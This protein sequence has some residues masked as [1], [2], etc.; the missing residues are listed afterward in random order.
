MP[1]EGFR[2][3]V[4]VAPDAIVIVDD[5]GKIISINRLAEEMFGYTRAELIGNDVEM[6]IPV[7]HLSAH[8]GH[9][10]KYTNEPR[11]RPMGTGQ[12]L[13]GRRKDGSEFPVEISLSPFTSP[14]GTQIISIIRDIT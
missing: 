1:D 4:E 12:Q 5:H 10:T 8:V 7:R 3:F 13:S 2:A 9:R 14:E 11:R 6:L